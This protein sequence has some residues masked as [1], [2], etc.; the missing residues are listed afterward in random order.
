MKDAI[1]TSWQ[2]NATEWVKVIEEAQIPSRKYTNQAIVCYLESDS[3]KHHMVDMG[4]G[5]GWL[6]R[7]IT[8]LGKEG[9]GIDATEDL[10]KNARQKGYEPF[11]QLTYEEI[12]AG[13][14]IPE[15]PFD[16]AVFNFSI[17]QEKNLHKLFKMTKKNL[18]EDGTIVIQTLHPYF[19]V[20]NGYGYQSQLIEDSWKGLPG[21]FVD[22]H[23]WYARTFENWFQ[24]FKESG[25]QMLQMQEV[26]NDK[27]IPL[28]L[29]IE[30]G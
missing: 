23:T 6:T 26:C 11:Y 13:A 21:N 2:K 17:Y 12:M 19:L 30:I 14:N 29:I 8:A 20:Q 1:K 27:N 16:M 24:V 28:S 4:C 3:E 10:L 15:G 5:E 18:V 9:V 22:G 7:Q 25:L